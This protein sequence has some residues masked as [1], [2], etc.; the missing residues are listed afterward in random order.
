MLIVQNIHLQLCQKGIFS[1]RYIYRYVDPFHA[2]FSIFSDGTTPKPSSH[3]ALSY[4]Y[5]VSTSFIP[6]LHF[7]LLHNSISDSIPD[8]F[9]LRFNNCSLVMWLK[10]THSLTGDFWT[11]SIPLLF[12][13]FRKRFNWRLD[14]IPIRSR[15][16]YL[17]FI[18]KSSYVW[19]VYSTG[20][21][22]F[23]ATLINC[24]QSDSVGKFGILLVKPS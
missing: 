1:H 14:W 21:F 23:W 9:C 16:F 19:I 10:L 2:D 24:L 4:R 15:V 6:I 22:W 5:R 7:A 12:C 3:I 20:R 8:S 11:L 17:N 13:I 18:C